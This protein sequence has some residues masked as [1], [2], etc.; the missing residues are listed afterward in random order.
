[1]KPLSPLLCSKCGTPVPN[2]YVQSQNARIVGRLGG[3]PAVLHRCQKCQREMT[4][5]EWKNHRKLKDC[6]R[7]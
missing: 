4:G 2:A 5:R 1:M 6:T 7:R 3:R